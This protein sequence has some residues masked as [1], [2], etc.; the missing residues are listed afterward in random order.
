MPYVAAAQLHAFSSPAFVPPELSDGSEVRTAIIHPSIDPLSAKNQPL[1]R[2]DIHGILTHVG[3]VKDGS[4]SSRE[5]RRGD[6]SRGL[7]EYG[8]DV[9][10]T[11]PSPRFAEPLV[12]QVSRWDRLKDPIGVLRCFCEHV[13]DR[14]PAQLILAGPSVGSV[15]DDPEAAEVLTETEAFWRTLPHAERRHVQLACLPMKDRDENAAIVNALQRQAAVIVQ[16][17]I[18]EGFG[19]TVTEAMWKEKPVVAAAV[20][21]IP[22]QIDDLRDGRLVD[23]TDLPAFGGAIADLLEDPEAGATL[24]RA[25]HERVTAHFLPDRHLLQFDALIRQL[26]EEREA[27]RA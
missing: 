11:G 3:L 21:G 1:R 2:R 7:V 22:E 8:C 18:A 17:S 6:G 16:K 26:A 24:G 23:P 4:G 27:A 14:V 10:R 20:G 9:L 25:A 5:F 15:A 13:L 19:L 12:V